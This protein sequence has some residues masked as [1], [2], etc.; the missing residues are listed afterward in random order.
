MSRLL[1]DTWL[2]LTLRWQMTWNGFRSRPSI[3]RALSLLFGVA[4]LGAA[5]AGTSVLGRIFGLL[6]RRFPDVAL[7]GLLPGVILTAI[8]LILLLS[9]FGVPLGSRFLSSDL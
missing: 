5:G 7:E 2:L 8:S 1:S 4:F 9:S 3:R 6:L